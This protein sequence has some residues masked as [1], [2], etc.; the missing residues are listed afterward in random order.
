MVAWDVPV[1]HKRSGHIL[2]RTSECAPCQKSPTVRQSRPRIS[3]FAAEESVT[4]AMHVRADTRSYL[5]KII[6]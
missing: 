6:F 4:P 3:S 5:K 1:T 2:E